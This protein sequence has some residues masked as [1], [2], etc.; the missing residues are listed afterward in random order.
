[1]SST[2]ALVLLGVAALILAVIGDGQEHTAQRVAMGHDRRVGVGGGL[3]RRVLLVRPQVAVLALCIPGRQIVGIRKPAEK[4]ADIGI[5]LGIEGHGIV[6]VVARL[7]PRIEDGL[8]IGIVRMQRRGDALHRVVE[9]RAAHAPCLD[10]ELRVGA[11]E[12]LVFPDRLALVVVDFLSR[13]DPAGIGDRGGGIAEIERTGLRLGLG[14]RVAA[15]TVRIDEMQLDRGL[16]SR[17][18]IADMGLAGD[19]CRADRDS[20]EIIDDAG[21]GRAELRDGERAR[22]WSRRRRPRCRVGARSTVKLSKESPSTG[23]AALPLKRGAGQHAEG[24]E[25]GLGAVAVGIGDQ[26]RLQHAIVIARPTPR[27]RRHR[28]VETR[29][30]SYSS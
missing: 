30:R 9:E 12:R 24:V 10:A 7:L 22:V 26:L 1:M 21:R 17:R 13:G 29:S 23:P 25:P 19:R 3:R 28:R 15:E 6:D 20:S 16:R 27:S 2:D 5:G 18:E 4:H 11:E 14:L 8:L